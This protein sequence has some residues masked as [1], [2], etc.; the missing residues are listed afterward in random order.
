MF[1]EYIA[2]WRLPNEMYFVI[3][4]PKTQLSQES[5]A[6]RSND[7]WCISTLQKLRQASPLSLKVALRSVSLSH[8]F[9]FFLKYCV[10]GNSLWVKDLKFL[11]RIGCLLI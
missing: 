8:L 7:P 10:I 2:A 3:M 5:E 9:I 1:V 11:I 6:T 4:L